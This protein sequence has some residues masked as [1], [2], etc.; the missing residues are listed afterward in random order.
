MRA[1]AVYALGTFTNSLTE[2]SE[3]GNTIDQSVVM[4]LVNSVKDDMSSL[5]RKE[6]VRA[7]QWFVLIFEHAFLSVASQEIN[8]S[9][10]N[11]D[12]TKTPTGM[13][14]NASR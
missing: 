5:V 9:S 3:H 4:T 2:R 12:V 8:D 14:K 7:L 1:A 6:L 13:R 11:H 10:A